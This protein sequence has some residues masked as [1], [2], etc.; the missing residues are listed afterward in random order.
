[1]ALTLLASLGAPPAGASHPWGGLDLCRTYPERMPPPLDPG[2]LPDPEGP[3]P[4]LLGRYCDQCH[5]PPG[6]GQHT[7]SEWAEV[8]ERMVLVMGATARFRA[9]LRPVHLPDPGERATLLGYLQTHAL[10]PLARG[11]DAP[12]GYR[13]LCGDC[14]AVP[15]PAAY[16]GADWSAL[17]ERMADHRRTM[18]RPP[19]DPAQQAQVHAF[20]GVSRAPAGAAEAVPG[21]APVAAP[22]GRWLALGPFF[23]LALLG[24]GRWWAHRG[25]RT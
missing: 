6:P 11:A 19:A 23:A 18:A 20:L 8:L 12:P 2:A 14:H 9:Q 7:A 15:D 13:T 1:V 24:A 22:Y 16:R 17:L 5:H 3:G 25:G 4:R 10:R 21:G